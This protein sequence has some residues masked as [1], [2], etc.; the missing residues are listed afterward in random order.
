LVR[1]SACLFVF[2]CLPWF[3]FQFSNGV[4]NLLQVADVDA[5][6]EQRQKPP[7]RE[8]ALVALCVDV[9]VTINLNGRGVDILGVQHGASSSPSKRYA[10]SSN[11][12]TR[13][14]SLS[15]GLCASSRTIALAAGWSGHISGAR[16]KEA[17]TRVNSSSKVKT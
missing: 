1:F 3:L 4:L 6:A 12:G 16:S 2:L 7:A 11:L 17:C 10:G 14:G 13:P 9:T 8:E 15:D 5:H